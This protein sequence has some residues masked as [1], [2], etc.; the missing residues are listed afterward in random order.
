M[1]LLRNATLASGDRLDIALG[2]GVISAIERPGGVGAEEEETSLDLDG[3]LCSGRR[4]ILMRTS[5][6][7]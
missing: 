6:R 4:P 5:T 2:N 3:Y 1:T 7:P